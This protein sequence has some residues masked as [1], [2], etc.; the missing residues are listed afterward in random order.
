MFGW[1]KR[2]GYI[3]PTVMEVVPYEFYRFAPDGIGLVGVTC[4]IDD[5]SQEYFDQA[6]AQVTT[7]ATYLGSR[8]VD[9]ILHGGGPLVV[10]RGKG[11]EETIVKE[12]ETAG[13]VPATTGVRAAMQALRHFGARR[14]VIASPYPERHNS[15]M[16]G[17]LAQHGFDIVRA[18]GMD[19]PF[20]KLQAV[21]PT[22]IKKF[23]AGVLARAS[24]CDALYLPCPQWQAAQTVADLEQECGVPAVAY[25][26]ASFFSAFK[27]LGINDAIRGHGWLLASLAEN[28]R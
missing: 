15:A 24:G 28:R 13:G 20:K 5:W 8:G 4:N 6:L 12:I 26:H 16:A 22:E 14:V 17:Y 7:A 23:A 10:A 3:G 25:T 1:R 21:G 27:A 9:Y 19:V 18:E 11:Y 2:I